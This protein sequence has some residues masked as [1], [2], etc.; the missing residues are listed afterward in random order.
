[1]FLSSFG[2]LHNVYSVMVRVESNRLKAQSCVITTPVHYIYW[3][4]FPLNRY[5]K[6]SQ[7]FLSCSSGSNLCIMMRTVRN[8]NLHKYKLLSPSCKY[9]LWME[10]SFEST[11]ELVQFF[12]T[13]ARGHLC[14]FNAH[15]VIKSSKNKAGGSHD[16]NLLAGRTVRRCL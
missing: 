9:F 4:A 2:Q 15:E 6:A 16:T 3:Y 10:V 8:S 12:Q 11:Q 5:I 1:M 7:C 13:L 14:R